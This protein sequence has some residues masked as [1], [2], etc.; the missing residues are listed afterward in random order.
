MILPKSSITGESPTTIRDSETIEIMPRLD[1]ILDATHLD[2]FGCPPFPFTHN[3]QQSS[4]MAETINGGASFR[5]PMAQ[6]GG[7]N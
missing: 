5:L 3:H 6:G 7:E 1:E 4:D 2:G